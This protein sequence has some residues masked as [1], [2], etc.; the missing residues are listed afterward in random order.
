M[1]NLSLLLPRD[2]NSQPVHDPLSMYKISDQDALS[3]PQY[4]GFLAH[5]SAYYVQKWDVAGQS[6]RYY[7]GKGDYLTAWANRAS[8]AYDYFDD[9][10]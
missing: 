6:F 1:P 8:L 4:F 5:D 7:A 3:D 2:G 9:I 10:F